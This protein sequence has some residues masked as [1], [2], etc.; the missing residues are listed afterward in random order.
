MIDVYKCLDFIRDEAPAYARAKAD[1]IYCDEYRKSLKALLMAQSTAKTAV[2][3]E[4]EAYSSPEYI[5]HLEALRVAVE[6]EETLRWR[7]IGAE[8]KIECWRSLEA[9]N[10]RMDKGAM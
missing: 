5:A 10:R 6:A 8:A 7:L 9:S 3:R 2:E 1:R 4:Q